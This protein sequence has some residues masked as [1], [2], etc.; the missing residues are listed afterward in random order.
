MPFDQSLAD[1]VRKGLARR[2]NVESKKMFGGLGFLLN[3]NLLVGVMGGSL[4]VRVG[5]DE[6]DYALLEPHV[7]VFDFTGKPLKGWVVVHPAGLA[8]DEHL[9]GW[10]RRALTFVGKLPPK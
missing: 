9:S 10:L 1:R 6:Y 2:K 8:D 5:P 7:K 4:I 3:G